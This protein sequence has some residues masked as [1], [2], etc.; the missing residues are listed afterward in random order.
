MPEGVVRRLAPSDLSKCLPAYGALDADAAFFVDAGL[1]H[2]VQV[3]RA[4]RSMSARMRAA[5]RAEGLVLYDDRGTVA[6][7]SGDRGDRG[8]TLLGGTRGAFRA[9]LRRWPDEAAWRDVGMAVGAALGLP[10]QFRAATQLGGRGWVWGQRT[11]VMGILNLTPDSFSDG[12]RLGSLEAAVREAERLVNEGADMLD[13]GGESTRPGADPVPADE[14]IRRVLPVIEALKERCDVPISIDTYKAA[15]A[16]AAISVGA[17]MVND[18]SG[19][20]GDPDM[21]GTVARLGV[22]VVIMHML[23][24][25]KTM[26]VEPRYQSVVPEVMGTLAESVDKAIAAGVKPENIIV[27]PGIGFGK[28]LPHN[29]TLM[30]R[31]RD[32]R[33]LGYPVLMGTSRKSMIGEVLRLPVSERIEGTAATVALSV[34]GLADIVR[35]HD[36]AAMQ[37]VVRVADAIVRGDPA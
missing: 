20:R 18:V 26:Q 19:L 11:Y 35:V 13:L 29:L 14:E 10:V 3:R 25:P 27:D 5:L 16:E 37:R 32:M 1:D 22:P 6:A 8:R 23:G 12:G 15:V 9:V 34:A 17:D 7:A 33:S 24:V 30:R 4:S 2:W 28:N 36:V 21:V 31:L